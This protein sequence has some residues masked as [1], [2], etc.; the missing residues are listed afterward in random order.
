MRDG[1]CLGDWA[2]TQSCV[3]L[4]SGE[5]ELNAALKGGVEL[6]GLR[7]LMTEIHLETTLQIKGD[8]SACHGTLHR[9]GCGKVK[10]LELKQLW[11]Q[12]KVKE[13]AI[14]YAKIPREQNPAD[15]FTK[16]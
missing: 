9:E 12:G 16:N 11:L 7:T 8:S 1:H 14:S 6:I 13:G 2:R 15:S 3:A 4:S 5:A 10:H